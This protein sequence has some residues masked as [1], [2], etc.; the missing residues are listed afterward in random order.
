M[1]DL[2]SAIRPTPRFAG[3]EEL[4]AAEGVWRAVH[5]LPG[6]ELLPPTDRID[7]RLVVVELGGDVVGAG[8]GVMVDAAG[9]RRMRLQR[10]AVLILHLRTK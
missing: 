1:S 10:L 8:L 2:S 7:H 4:P 9:E 6:A 3:P 5:P